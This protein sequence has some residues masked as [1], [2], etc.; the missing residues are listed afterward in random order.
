MYTVKPGGEIR[1]SSGPNLGQVIG[2][3]PRDPAEYAV[4]VARTTPNSLVASLGLSS[5]DTPAKPVTKVWENFS[6]MEKHNLYELDKPKYD[7]LRAEYLARTQPNEQPETPPNAPPIQV[8]RR[9]EDMQP[10]EKHS[11]LFENLEA[12]D[13]LR[14]EFLNRT[15]QGEKIEPERLVRQQ[16]LGKR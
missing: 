2:Y 11:L 14:A 9:W 4:F 1:A 8:S 13:A 12:Y 7:S 15:G 16:N 6:I 3:I 5:N 10:M